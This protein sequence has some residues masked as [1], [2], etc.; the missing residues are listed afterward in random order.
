M[1]ESE[2]VPVKSHKYHF[3]DMSEG[4]VLSTALPEGGLFF[5]L[6]PA[7]WSPTSSWM[8]REIRPQ[9]AWAWPLDRRG[10]IVVECAFRHQ[11]G[12]GRFRQKLDES[13]QKILLVL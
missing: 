12:V 11:G 13:I 5:P 8:P 4:M 10:V 9:Q 3:L 6:R 2:N 7:S 1:R